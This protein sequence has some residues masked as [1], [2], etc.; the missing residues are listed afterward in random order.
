MK[1]GDQDQTRQDPGAGGAVRQCLL[2]PQLCQPGV[3]HDG[4]AGNLFRR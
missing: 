1:V 4:C 3:D 2:D